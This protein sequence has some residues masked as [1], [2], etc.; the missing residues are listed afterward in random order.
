LNI[1]DQ[2]GWL[3]DIPRPV[4][5]TRPAKATMSTYS[6]VLH[7]PNGRAKQGNDQNKQRDSCSETIRAVL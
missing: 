4:S 7:Q 2:I 3:M 6:S 1:I 5:Q